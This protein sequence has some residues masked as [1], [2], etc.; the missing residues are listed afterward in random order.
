[1]NHDETD[2]NKWREKRHEWLPYVKN[3][4]LC[5]AYSYA[6][7]IICMEE[8]TRFPLKYCFSLPGLGWKYFISFRTE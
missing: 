1:M 3:D 5:T 4:I 2:G 6:R 7:Y 8:L